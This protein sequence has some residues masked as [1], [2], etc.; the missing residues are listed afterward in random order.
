MASPQGPHGPKIFQENKGAHK[1]LSMVELARPK[2]ITS[3]WPNGKTTPKGMRLCSKSTPDGS[4]VDKAL[5][6]H[7]KCDE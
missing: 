3:L 2:N 6:H 7:I 4:I 5:A 1:M